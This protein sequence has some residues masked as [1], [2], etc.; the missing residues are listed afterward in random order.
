MTE[1]QIRRKLIEAGFDMTAIIEI[2]R[3]SVEIGY[4]NEERYVSL[5]LRDQTDAA[6]DKVLEILGWHSLKSRGWGGWGAS[7]GSPDRVLSYAETCGFCD[8][9]SIHHY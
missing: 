2:S 3:D 1:R 4:L 8:P 6:A 9:A 5:E 7:P